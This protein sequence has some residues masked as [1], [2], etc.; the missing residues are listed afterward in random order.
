VT[1][2][3]GI[4]YEYQV[5]G[6]AQDAGGVMPSMFVA[7]VWL[8]IVAL[9]IVPL[10]VTPASP[11]GPLSVAPVL[12]LSLPVVEDDELVLLLVVALSLCAASPAVPLS[13][14]VEVLLEPLLPLVLLDEQA[15]SQANAVVPMMVTAKEIGFLNM[16]DSLSASGQP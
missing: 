13:L 12:P 1:V 2:P 14:C 10:H 3:G 15:A 7:F 11:V 6:S 4:G 16:N 8:S 9:V 5:P